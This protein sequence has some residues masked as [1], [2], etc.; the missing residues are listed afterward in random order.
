LEEVFLPSC[1][2]LLPLM[3]GMESAE[4]QQEEGK[5]IYASK[6]HSFH[7]GKGRQ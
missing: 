2:P 5:G 1:H 4:G 6:K 7:P 3:K